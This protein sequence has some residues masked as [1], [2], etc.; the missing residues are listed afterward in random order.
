[1]RFKPPVETYDENSVRLN[2]PGFLVLRPLEKSATN[3]QNSTSGPAQEKLTDQVGFK[4]AIALGTVLGVM[5]ILGV[6]AFIKMRKKLD[7]VVEQMP[8]YQEFIEKD[9]KI[10]H[11]LAA[12]VESVVH[13]LPATEKPAELSV[14]GKEE[15]I[16]EIQAV[17][18]HSP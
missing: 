8:Q 3:S 1:L 7:K 15:L 14:S 13:E 17:G 12:Q 9:A 5:V 2:S 10:R 6:G 11:E 4:V 16:I 18:S